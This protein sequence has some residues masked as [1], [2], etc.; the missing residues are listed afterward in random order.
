[1]AP[2]EKKIGLAAEMSAKRFRDIILFWG[3]GASGV[4]GLIYEV[5]W[6]RALTNTVGATTYSFSILLAAYMAGLALGGHYGGAYLKHRKDHVV[7]F[8]ALQLCT[9]VFG[10]ATL[11][12][13][14]NLQTL[15]GAIFYQLRGFFYLFTAAQLILVFLIMLVPTT[16]MGAGFPVIVEAWSLRVTEIGRNAGNVYSINTWGAVVGAL[17]SGFILVPMAGLRSANLTAVSINLALAFLAL[18]IAG[19]R[20]LAV[21]VLVLFSVTPFIVLPNLPP[22]LAF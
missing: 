7:V 15:Y 18:L 20:R 22:Y 16:L 13:I 19:Y 4:A 5:V 9:G 1:M 21:A 14:S 11:Y 6:S 8:G 17:A 2:L 12:V 10:L 3:F